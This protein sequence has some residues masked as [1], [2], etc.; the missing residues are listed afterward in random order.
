MPFYMR[1]PESGIPGFSVIAARIIPLSDVRIRYDTEVILDEG[2]EGFFVIGNDIIPLWNGV[3][4]E[5]AFNLHFP[6]NKMRHNERGR[7]ENVA[8]YVY[9][10][11]VSGCSVGLSSQLEFVD[12]EDGKRKKLRTYWNYSL[13]LSYVNGDGL[14]RH[15]EKSDNWTLTLTDCCSIC[16]ESGDLAQLL[17]D[18]IREALEGENGVPFS[19]IRQKERMIEENIKAAFNKNSTKITGF[20]IDRLRIGNIELVD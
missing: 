9:R 13:T 19:M 7:L 2:T 16:R 15:I 17:S 12:K 5:D 6:N 20:K 14:R 1:L 4:L 3:A 10:K 8:F 18:E 11:D